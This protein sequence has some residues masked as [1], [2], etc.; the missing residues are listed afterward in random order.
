MDANQKPFTTRWPIV[1]LN[2]HGDPHI[3]LVPAKAGTHNPR[4]WWVQRV[5]PPPQNEGPRRHDERDGTHARGPC[6]RR[7]DSKGVFSTLVLQVDTT[8]S[9]GEKAP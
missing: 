4:R 2:S 8:R 6:F 1:G 7:D 5:S 9:V 3:V